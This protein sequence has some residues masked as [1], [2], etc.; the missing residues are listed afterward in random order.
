MLFNGLHIRPDS[1]SG[2]WSEEGL[3]IQPLRVKKKPATGHFFPQLFLTAFAD[4]R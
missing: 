4:L 1:G 3:G 2:D